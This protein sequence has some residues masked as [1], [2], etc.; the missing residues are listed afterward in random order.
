METIGRLAGGIAHYYNNLMHMILGC[1]DIVL[2][3]VAPGDPIRGDVE[4]I[5]EA[6]RRAATITKQ[7]LAFGQKQILRIERLNLNDLILES[8]QLLQQ[9]AG[10][11]AEILLRLEQHVSPVRGDRDQ[12]KE[13]LVHLA[14]NAR[15]TME[16]EAAHGSTKPRAQ[17][18]EVVPG[19]RMIQDYRVT[20][21]TSEVHVGAEHGP[22]N[23]DLPA[24]EYVRLTFSDTSPGIPDEIAAHI[25]E[26]FYSVRDLTQGTGMG[27]ATAYGAV[28]QM[29]GDI[30]IATASGEG[31]TFTVFL[32]VWNDA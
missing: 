29:G 26:P 10:S 30:R 18:T 21:E 15:S 32:P 16:N 20:V 8:R 19:A 25:F 9:T 6:A 13:L 2:E 28:R 3:N 11:G 4:D 5:R 12:I 22:R 17:G 27:L 14:M 24:G 1:S 31:T 7:V 23:P